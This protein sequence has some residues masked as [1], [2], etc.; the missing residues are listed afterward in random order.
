M[1]QWY[2]DTLTEFEPKVGFKTRFDV[3]HEGKVFPH[4]IKGTVIVPGEKISYEWKFGGYPANSSV[5]FELR[6]N[7]DET[8][9]VLTHE[10]L[11]S[12][13]GQIHP[14]LSLQNFEKGWTHLIGTSLKNFVE[15][16]LRI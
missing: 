12:F 9:I 13:R 15:K 7:Q 4:I 8:R 2:F 5:S 10:K 14:E 11:A 16:N 1:K 6:N 3:Q